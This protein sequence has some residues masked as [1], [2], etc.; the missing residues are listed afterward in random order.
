MDSIF[1]FLTP[2]GKVIRSFDDLPADLADVTVFEG[3]PGDRFKVKAWE[4]N[5][6]LEVSATRETLWTEVDPGT[7]HI[8]KAIAAMENRRL[9]ESE[10]DR[11][12]RERRNREKACKRAKRAVRRTCKAM[13]ASALLTLTYRACETDLKVVKRDLLKFNQRV[14]RVIPGFCFVAAFE[15]QKRGAWHMHLATRSI[16]K[17]LNGPKGVK[18]K[19]F[20]LLRSIWRSVVGERGGNVDVSNKQRS[21]R[22]AA[23]I[24]SYISAYIAKDFEDGDKWVN[25]Y[26]VYGASNEAMAD[27]R[28]Q[29]FRP[30]KEIQL[31]YAN[32]AVEAITLCVGLMAEGSEV[33]NM[34]YSRFGS[35]FYLAAESPS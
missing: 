17:L 8:G 3:V 35:A 26:A 16:P 25:R 29:M 28:E 14:K 12:R 1:R 5:G 34:L 6:H 33:V 27:G 18:V 9:G 11:M 4:C 23:R 7:V 24:A 19:S 22:S 15:K 10:A 30:P 20:D 31:G 21:M 2:Y 13:G 32:D